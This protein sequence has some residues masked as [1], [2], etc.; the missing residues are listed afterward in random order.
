[1]GYNNPWQIHKLKGSL[2]L[3]MLQ[4]TNGGWSLMLLEAAISMCFPFA[5]YKKPSVFHLTLRDVP[6]V[7]K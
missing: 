2:T 5:L 1:M 3:E 6:Y 7:S 4:I